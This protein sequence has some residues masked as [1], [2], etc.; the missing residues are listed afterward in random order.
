MAV[1]L[2]LPVYI[3]WRAISQSGMQPL[4][5]PLRLAAGFQVL[6]VLLWA[7]LIVFRH[8]VGDLPDAIVDRGWN[9]FTALFFAGALVTTLVALW[10]TVEARDDDSTLLVPVL[11]AMTSG[12][13]LI[14]GAELFYVTDV[15]NSRLNT[16][17]KFYYQ[18]WLLLGVAGAAGAWWLYQELKAQAGASVQLVRGAW[19]GIAALLV[20]GALLYPLGA[21]L[22]RTDG[23]SK[24]GRTLDAAAGNYGSPTDV[25][26][27]VVSWLLRNADPRDRLVEAVTGSYSS[28]GRFSSWTGVPTIL[29]WPGHERQWGRDG[30]ELARRET[31]VRTV[32]STP[33]LEEALSILQQYGVTYI[34][35]GVVE[36][37]TYPAE[38]LVKFEA[39]QRV[40][41]AE[42]GSLYRVPPAAGDTDGQGTGLT[43]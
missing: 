15:F 8:G 7:L 22:S 1:T 35:V 12:L 18:A 11:A 31:D 3:V 39:L 6:M 41:G 33:S 42:T 19:A 32:Y 13:L 25:E 30:N 26:K 5:R 9:W 20:A 17:F 36:R 14:F 10:R 37:A 34:A 21:T 16:V 27:D 23:L 4:G 28:G 40:A 43:P 2:P 24:D 29:G 38:G